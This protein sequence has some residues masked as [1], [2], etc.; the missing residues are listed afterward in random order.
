MNA[1]ET[2]YRFVENQ[3]L[4]WRLLMGWQDLHPLI[5]KAYQ[6]K[7]GKVKKPKGFAA[8]SKERHLEVSSLGGKNKHENYSNAT[9]SEKQTDT[10]EPRIKLEDVLNTLGDDNE[11]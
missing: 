11:L 3:N 7:G 9:K 4:L 8:M 6:S 1:N 5:R 10:S 2:N